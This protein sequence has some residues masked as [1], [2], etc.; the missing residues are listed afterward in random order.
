M[1]K[2]LLHTQHVTPGVVATETGPGAQH[3]QQ[4]ISSTV[5]TG[6]RLLTVQWSGQSQH[7]SSEA[8]RSAFEYTL[9][10]GV[11]LLLFFVFFYQGLNFDL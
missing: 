8:G 11:L 9:K 1:E 7:S 6:G 3:M 10:G 2:S 4:L 5:Q